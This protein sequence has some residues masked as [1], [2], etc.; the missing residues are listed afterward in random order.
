LVY[1][2]EMSC[3]SGQYWAGVF[4]SLLCLALSGLGSD[5]AIERGWLL[6]DDDE[7]PRGMTPRVD[8]LHL[9]SCHV[10]RGVAVACANVGNGTEDVAVIF[11]VLAVVQIQH[12]ALVR[13]HL[14]STT[15]LLNALMLCSAIANAVL[16][17]MGMLLLVMGSGEGENQSSLFAGAYVSFYGVALIATGVRLFQVA[18]GMAVFETPNNEIF[19]EQVS[20][21]F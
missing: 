11:L 21:T 15:E 5:V 8:R 16:T 2:P 4:L 6:A 9:Y 7:V 10:T 18:K 3:G 19:P 17:P 14:P 1:A 13:L 20:V 12:L